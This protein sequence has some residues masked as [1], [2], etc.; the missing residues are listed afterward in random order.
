[1]ITLDEYAAQS[2]LDEDIEQLA[3]DT[4]QDRD[5][6]DQLERELT[7]RR[8]RELRARRIAMGRESDGERNAVADW[9]AGTRRSR[10]AVII[11]FA[12]EIWPNEGV[13][14]ETAHLLCDELEHFMGTRTREL[15]PDAPQVI[16]GL[17]AGTLQRAGDVDPQADTDQPPS[18]GSA[19]EEP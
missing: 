11:A 10:N 18:S 14:G 12:R 9:P 13:K 8:L 17:E 6:W 1:M 5:L 2:N 3:A 15:P 19:R 7:V 16:A 4:G